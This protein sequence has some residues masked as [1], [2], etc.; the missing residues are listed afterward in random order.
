MLNYLSEKSGNSDRDTHNDQKVHRFNIS[1][2]VSPTFLVLEK[3][4][5]HG[6]L[7]IAQQGIEIQFS[8]EKYNGLPIFV[9]YSK[10]TCIHLNETLIFGYDEVY[11]ILENINLSEA[12]SLSVKCQ[13]PQICIS[14]AIGDI[15]CSFSEFKKKI[16]NQAITHESKDVNDVD[17]WDIL[18]SYPNISVSVIIDS[19]QVYSLDS[20]NKSIAYILVKKFSF[21]NSLTHSNDITLQRSLQIALLDVSAGICPRIL[22]LS[23]PFFEFEAK[24]IKNLKLLA[25]IFLLRDNLKF[26]LVWIRKNFKFNFLILQRT[27]P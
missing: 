15:F 6:D 20:Q 14:P 3:C 2:K 10:E 21:V 13:S 27:K 18:M 5:S 23:I 16:S 17:I 25:D 8:N 11:F 12:I 26:V 9:F 24:Y 22:L 7:K 19:T 4:M 1:L